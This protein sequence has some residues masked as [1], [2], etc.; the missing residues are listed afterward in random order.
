ML[1]IFQTTA[2]NIESK[3]TNNITLKVSRLENTKC[4]NLLKKSKINK[5][6]TD[7]LITDECLRFP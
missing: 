5:K 7:L 6:K 4:Y 2:N 3:Q 1:N